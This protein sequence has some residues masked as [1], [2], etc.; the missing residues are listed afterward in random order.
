MLSLFDLTFPIVDATELYDI[1]ISKF[2]KFLGRLLAAVTASAI[3]QNQL[4]LIGELG[5]FIRADA[6]VRNID[7]FVFVT[8]L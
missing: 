2:N 5:Y 4:I 7:P 1:R 6:F 8:L 3:Y